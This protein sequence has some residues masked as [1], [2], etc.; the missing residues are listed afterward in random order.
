M[1]KEIDLKTIRTNL[2]VSRAALAEEFG[3]DVT[4]VCRWEKY[5]IPARGASRKA[6]E[7][8]IEEVA[9]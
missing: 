3:V 1:E 4:T 9:A 8:W 6:I 2:K 7:K 5:G